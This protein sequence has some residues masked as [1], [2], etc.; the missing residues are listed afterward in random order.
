MNRPGNWSFKSIKKNTN[1]NIMEPF[2]RYF[3]FHASDYEIT[4]HVRKVE[5]KLLK[6]FGQS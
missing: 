1:T 6:T 2:A 3:A 4:E 5:L